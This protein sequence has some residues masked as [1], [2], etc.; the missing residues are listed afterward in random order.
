MDDKY[1]PIKS[2][3]IVGQSVSVKKVHQFLTNKKRR[4]NCIILT[5][6]PGIGKTL[7]AEIIAKELNFDVK[8]IDDDH[9][10]KKTMN[11]SSMFN[12]KKE[13]VIIYESDFMKSPANDVKLIKKSRQSIIFICNNEEIDKYKTLKS[14]SEVVYMRC[15]TQ[16]EQNRYLTK[17]V[18][19][20]KLDISKENIKIACENSQGD[21]RYLL[22]N[23]YFWKENLGKNMYGKDGNFFNIFKM[24]PKFFDFCVTIE[25]RCDKYFIDTYYLPQLLFFNYPNVKVAK[26]ESEFDELSKNVKEQAL[27][28]KIKKAKEEAKKLGKKVTK[29]KKPKI[30]EED[31]NVLYKLEKMSLCTETMSCS[32]L[33][34]YESNDIYKYLISGACSNYS[35]MLL[36]KDM[37][38][39]KPKSTTKLIYQ[40]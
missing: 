21:M 9:D 15:P 27:K 8:H 18:K 25:D 31:M 26:I 22:L 29:I 34:S 4:K 13:V 35:G 23:F 3:D 28:N 12:K 37:K 40:Q 16:S 11:V 7:L 6:K 2:K 36:E 38:Y 33:F 17:I 20:E 10:L 1:K 24:V 39:S 5:G 19:K 32:D 14:V 30:S